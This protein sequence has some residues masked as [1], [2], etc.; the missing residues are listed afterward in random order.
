MKYAHVQRRVQQPLL[1]IYSVLSLGVLWVSGQAAKGYRST[2]PSCA[3][4]F[5]GTSHDATKT[6]AVL[7]PSANAA[8]H[9][10]L[11]LQITLLTILN[12][13]LTG[14]TA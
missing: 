4:V 2:T 14:Y 12:Y 10:A 6:S 11:G 1:W 13:I 7:V 8:L 5:L 3:L 9:T